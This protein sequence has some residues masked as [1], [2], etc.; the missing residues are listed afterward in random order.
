MSRKY[1]GKLYGI[2]F[3]EDLNCPPGKIYM[4]NDSYTDFARI[5]ARSRWQRIKGWVLWHI[6]RRRLQASAYTPLTPIKSMRPR[7]RKFTEIK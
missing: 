3:Y 7:R 1:V 2:D 4:M 6:F 5:D